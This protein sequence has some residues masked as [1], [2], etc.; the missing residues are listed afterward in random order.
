MLC[1]EFLP[2][3]RYL[4]TKSIGLALDIENLIKGLWYRV[5]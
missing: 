2:D 3:S 4:E 1:I 5:P